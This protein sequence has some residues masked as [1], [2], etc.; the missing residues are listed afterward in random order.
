MKSICIGQN[1][2]FLFCYSGAHCSISNYRFMSVPQFN[3]RN[4]VLLLIIVIVAV[5]RF[6]SFS[7]MGPLTVFTPVGAMALFGGA[8]FKGNIKPLLFPLLTLFLSDV[9]LAFTVLSEHRAG[10]LYSGWLW[11]YLAF[12]LMA[13]AGKLI[14]KNVTV[15]SIVM[16]VLVSTCIH[17]LISDLGGCLQ[18]NRFSMTLYVQRLITAIPYEWLFLAGTA[19][20]SAI[21][22]GAFEWLQ[23]RYASLKL[24]NNQHV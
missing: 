5:L 8:Y 11:T 15:K 13:V 17:W 9:V 1:I 12:A 16:A 22:F 20:Y 18:E 6:V 21:M 3:P 23:H 4:A 7:G 2:S 10:L 19:I 24:R 14:I